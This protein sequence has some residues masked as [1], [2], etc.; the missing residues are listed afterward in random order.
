MGDCWD[1]RSKWE[2]YNEKIDK[3]AHS[4]Q[5]SKVIRTCLARGKILENVGFFKETR[6]NLPFI[7]KYATI[8][9]ITHRYCELFYIQVLTMVIITE[10][11]TSTS[12]HDIFTYLDYFFPATFILSDFI[13]IY[14]HTVFSEK[15]NTKYILT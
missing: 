6:Q 9:T 15:T 2:I 13:H 14:F 10:T 1:D 11:L 12:H 7:E 8:S 3:H 5:N 4:V